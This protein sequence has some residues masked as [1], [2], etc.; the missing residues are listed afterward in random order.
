MADLVIY[1]SFGA[2]LFSLG[3]GLMGL[4]AP[5]R[6]LDLV[7]LQLAPGL[8]HSVSEVRA[9]YGGVFIGASLY[10]LITG[11]PQ[12]F[13]TLSAAW[14]CA[15][16]ARLASVFIDKAATRFNLASIAF[17]FAVGGL[18]GWPYLS[19]ALL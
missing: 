17:E 11:E 1:L 13:L 6:A 10:P 14:L 9:T 8:T 3:L 19:E 12:A 16:L 2:A 15:G 4:L 7:G 18:A 5:A